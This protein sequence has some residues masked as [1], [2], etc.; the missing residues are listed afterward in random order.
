MVEGQVSDPMRTNTKAEI[1]VLD[2]STIIAMI[3]NLNKFN[4]EKI[5]RQILLYEKT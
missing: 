1:K 3:V 2:F 5:I 4:L